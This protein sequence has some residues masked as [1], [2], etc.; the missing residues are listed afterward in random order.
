MQQNVVV[1]VYV[2]VYVC[3][4]VFHAY[5]RVVVRETACAGQPAWTPPNDTFPLFSAPPFR[6]KSFSQTNGIWSGQGR[7]GDG[8]DDSVPEPLVWG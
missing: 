1:S 2:Q 8:R 3:T 4:R 6:V 5:E 7:G